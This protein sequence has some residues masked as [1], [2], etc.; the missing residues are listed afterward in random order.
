M[1]LSASTTAFTQANEDCQA[2]A[3]G[4]DAMDPSSNLEA[5]T[6]EYELLCVIQNGQP[7]G[8]AIGKGKCRTLQHAMKAYDKVDYRKQGGSDYGL[9]DY[10]VVFKGDQYAV[11]HANQAVN[12]IVYR[13]YYFKRVR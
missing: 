8:K 9:W 6:A 13:K 2:R 11:L 5:L 4:I 12:S 3:D 10:R 7:V 1:F